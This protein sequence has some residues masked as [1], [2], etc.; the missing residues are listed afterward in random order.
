MASE[1]S[2]RRKNP[3]SF[4]F[5]WDLAAPHPERH[6]ERHRPTLEQDGERI[7]FLHIPGE[8]L[9][10]RDGFHALAVELLHHVAPL[11]AGFGG[12]GAVLDADHD[13]ALGRSKIEL[14]G[15]LRSNRT[16]LETEHRAR[17]SAARPL[18]LLGLALVGRL[19][20]LDLVGL[21]GLIPPDLHLGAAVGGEE[22]H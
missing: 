6:V 20:D 15:D 8:P 21:L 2:G 17:A 1:T 4:S 19:A 9:E 16:D 22:A 7:A 5:Y 10:V 3:E 11:H 12:R 14:A 18:L 13:H